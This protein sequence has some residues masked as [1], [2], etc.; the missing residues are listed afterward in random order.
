MAERAE[1]TTARPPPRR[2][3]PRWPRR[4]ATP[5]VP[6][7]IARRGDPE[8]PQPPR[9]R[10]GRARRA[11][12]PAAEPDA[13]Q[14][15]DRAAS[16][17][18]GGRAR[19]GSP[20]SGCSSAWAQLLEQ[21]IIRQVTPIYDT[22]ALGYS[23]MLVAAK[24]DPEHPWR[25]A[26]IVNSH[27]GVSHNYLRNHDFNMWFTIA[28]EPDSP[29]GLEGTL[30]VLGELTGAESIRQLPTLKLFKI[31]MDLEMEGDTKALASEGAEQQEALL[32]SVRLR[33]A[34]HRGDPRDAGRH[35]GRRRALRPGRAGARHGGRCAAR[36]PARDAGA[37]PA[38]P[39][40]GD[41]LPPPRRLLGERHGCLEGAGRADRRARPA[42]GGLPRHLALLPAPDLRGLALLGLHDGPRPLQ[43][44][45]RRGP[46]RDR[47]GD[48]H[49]RAR[50]ALLLDGVQEGPPAVLHRRLQ[51]WEAQHA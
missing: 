28:T 27:P 17:R 1:L 25:A 13:G 19:P 41:P 14:L 38:A 40:R 37:R 46:R 44:G 4:H 32:E 23:S 18:G 3:A 15:P 36:A 51:R 11:R 35:A 24:V 50:D 34:R 33:R 8:D 9:R 31:R 2:P 43:G 12:P 21:R 10:R 49:R 22:R 29:L 47:R 39:R 48:R 16:L 6:A 5:P 42:D 30:E 20:R 26:K 45:V 7:R